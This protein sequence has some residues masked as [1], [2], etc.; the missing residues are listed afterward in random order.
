MDENKL[1]F[2][3]ESE[4]DS[5]MDNEAVSTDVENGPSVDAEIAALD[6]DVTFGERAVPIL[7]DDEASLPD[8]PSVEPDNC[9][10]PEAA[11]AV[12]DDRPADNAAVY[13]PDEAVFPK[14]EDALA[15]SSENRFGKGDVEND[16]GPKRRRDGLGYAITGGVL[17]VICGVMLA[18]LISSF[19]SAEALIASLSPDRG[20]VGI[21]VIVAVMV[22]I[23][24]AVGC[25]M[26][27][28][29]LLYISSL[30][31]TRSEGVFK[32]ISIAQMSISMLF[33]L[34]SIILSVVV[35]AI[36]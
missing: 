11:V 5:N 14:R 24:S 27:S 10:M 20:F 16:D 8:E 32:Y 19:C 22:T 25:I 15:H 26:A 4:I 2:S 29:A 34:T 36:A 21:S 12:A 7:A 17:F 13:E 33:I 35:I 1:D 9:K 18:F 31:L 30:A 23:I 3:P 6:D 28:L